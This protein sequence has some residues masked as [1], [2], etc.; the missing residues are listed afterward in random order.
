MPQLQTHQG[1]TN[2]TIIVNAG[3]L[4][5]SATLDGHSLNIQADFNAT[6]PIEVIGAPSTAEDLFINGKKASLNINNNSIWSTNIEYAAPEIKLPDL[7]NLTWK[8]IDTLPEILSSYDDSAWIAANHTYTNNSAHALKTPTSLSA[9]DYGFNAGTLIYRGHFTANGNETT[10]SVNTQG[11]S[12]FASSVWINETYLG[13]WTGNSSYSSNTVEYTLPSSL[14]SGKQYVITVVIDNMGLDENWTVGQ[15]QMKAVRGITAYTF[16][17]QNASAIAWKLTGNL[18]GEDYMDSVRGPLNE[19][20]LYAER[21]GFHQPQPP[22]QN[23]NSST[24]FTGLTRAGIQ[25][26]STSFDLDIPEGWDIPMYFNIANTTSPA[27]AY[28][29][30]LYVNG[31]QYGKYVNTLGPQTSFPVPEGILNYRGTNWL[32]LALWVQEAAGASLDGLELVSTTPV[33]T[34]MGKVV[35]VDQPK[36]QKRH[37]AY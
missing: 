5:R 27:P 2:S 7:K 18:G 19:G 12:A 6:T 13:S 28:R 29:V 32:A 11:G 20:G 31:Y 24:P 37:G 33:L 15:D 26:Y 17:G 1:L 22:S 4:V 35:S 25:F 10:F 23:W 21:Q 3:Y 16:S 9:S 30:Q 14:E 34:S 8:S 36:Y